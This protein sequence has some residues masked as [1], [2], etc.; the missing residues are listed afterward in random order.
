M[1]LGN[2]QEDS[3]VQIIS[4]AQDIAM[5]PEEQAHNAM[6]TLDQDK[7][8]PSEIPYKHTI[9][10]T[11]GLMWPQTFALNHPAVG[12]LQQYVVFGCPVD[13]GE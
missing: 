12:L 6:E 8:I 4:P 9:G 3:E 10:K 7:A 5:S 13:C 1:Q 11:M 2:P